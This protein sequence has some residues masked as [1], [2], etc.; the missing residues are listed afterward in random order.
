MQLERNFVYIASTM[1][2]SENTAV[3]KKEAVSWYLFS[4]LKKM[5]FNVLSKKKT[6]QKQ[7]RSQK[8]SHWLSDTAGLL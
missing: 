8:A 6:P 1:Y 4:S 7:M 2:D 5:D 3:L